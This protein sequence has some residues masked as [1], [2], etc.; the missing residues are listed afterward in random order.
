[1]KKNKKEEDG[2]VL[3]ASRLTTRFIR[4]SGERENVQ[5]GAA[6]G[7]FVALLSCCVWQ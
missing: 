7:A 5:T 6:N 2:E 3:L 1:M 4:L